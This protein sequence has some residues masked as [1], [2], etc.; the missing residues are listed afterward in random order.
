MT[1]P[2]GQYLQASPATPAVVETSTPSTVL[3]EI[4]T[5]YLGPDGKAVSLRGNWWAIYTLWHKGLKLLGGE[6]TPPLS[7]YGDSRDSRAVLW[8][9][10]KV[11][12]WACKY[13]K[14]VLLM[15]C[16]VAEFKNRGEQ[17]SVA[18]D[19]MVEHFKRRFK[20]D[21]NSAVKTATS[22]FN[23]SGTASSKPKFLA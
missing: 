7:T 14:M 15:D 17:E 10:A 19:A 1:L 20:G 11:K 18:I 3:L 9:V 23:L 5:E 12:T 8:D 4:P 21:K 16:V 22:L 13:A 6:V 2:L